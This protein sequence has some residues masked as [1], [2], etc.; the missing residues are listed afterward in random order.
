M[1]MLVDVE[2]DEEDIPEV[3]PALLG[4]DREEMQKY[5]TS[6]TRMK[7]MRHPSLQ[8]ETHGNRMKAIRVPFNQENQRVIVDLTW[9]SSLFAHIPCPGPGDR[10]SGRYARVLSVIELKR[11]FLAPSIT[12]ECGPGTFTAGMAPKPWRLLCKMR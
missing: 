9:L 12:T 3:G 10:S 6:R 2:S 11:D 8:E 1:T 7:A 4:Q 5:T